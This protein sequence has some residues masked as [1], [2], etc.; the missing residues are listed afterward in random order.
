MK[1]N[2]FGEPVIEPGGDIGAAFS[3]MYGTDLE[4]PLTA[5]FVERG[6]DGWGCTIRDE[7]DHEVQVSGFESET[8]LREQLASARVDVA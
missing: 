5:W 6:D 3:E 2:F 4:A 7:E 8:Q 1:T